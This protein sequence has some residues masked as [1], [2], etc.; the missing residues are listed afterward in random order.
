MSYTTAGAIFLIGLFLVIFLFLN[1]GRQYAH[2]QK[3]RA[4]AVKPA[5][6]HI[7]EGAIFALFGLMIALILL[8]N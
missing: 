2:W 3:R 7:A 5:D 8:N 1:I 6:I 4:P